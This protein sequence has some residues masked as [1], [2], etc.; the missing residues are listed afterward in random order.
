MSYEPTPPP[1]P[2]FVP[3]PPEPPAP[4]III[5]PGTPM[6][7]RQGLAIAALVLG[8]LSLGSFCLVFCS[9]PL[10]IAG[11]ITGILGLKSSRRGLAMAGLILSVIGILVSVILF[12]AGV[13]LIP[14]NSVQN[15]NFVPTVVIP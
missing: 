10:G 7:N 1:A 9:T 3:P 12:I 2:E 8:I 11:I 6:T 5:P 4:D 14:W 15:W 13:A